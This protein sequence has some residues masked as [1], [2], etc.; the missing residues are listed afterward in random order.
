MN[1]KKETMK[2][3]LDAQKKAVNKK[4]LK[5]WWKDN[6]I[7]FCGLIA[8]VIAAIVSTIDLLI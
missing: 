7:S 6:W 2:D 4:H 5:E 8:A 3:F 1:Q